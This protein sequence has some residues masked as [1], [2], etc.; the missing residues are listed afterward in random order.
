MGTALGDPVLPAAAAIGGDR[1][2]AEGAVQD[3]FAKAVR[4][5][6]SYRDPPFPQNPE[7]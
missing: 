7:L 4:K 2:L 5:R 3:A 6:C 1:G